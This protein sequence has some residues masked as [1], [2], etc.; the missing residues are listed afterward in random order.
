M[1]AARGGTADVVSLRDREVRSGLR[2]TSEMRFR[3]GRADPQSHVALE[4]PRRHL[5][6]GNNGC[7]SHVLELCRCGIA[8]VSFAFRGWVDST[9]TELTAVEGQA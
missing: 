3:M 7:A 2:K 8:P 9:Q 6:A 1:A 4:Q 5:L